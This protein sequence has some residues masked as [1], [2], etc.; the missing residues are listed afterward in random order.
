[1][2][3]L[4]KKCCL[5]NVVAA[6]IKWPLNKSTTSYDMLDFKSINIKKIDT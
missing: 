2:K 6:A 1:M 5:E 3:C 4:F